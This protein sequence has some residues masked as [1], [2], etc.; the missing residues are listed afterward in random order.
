MPKP[1]TSPSGQQA[2]DSAKGKKTA[3]IN[4]VILKR[5]GDLKTLLSDLV[6]SNEDKAI[7]DLDLGQEIHKHTSEIE[8]LRNEMHQFQ[9]GMLSSFCDALDQRLKQSSVVSVDSETSHSLELSAPTAGPNVT[10]SNATEAHSDSEEV[11]TEGLQE[12]SWESIRS[13]FLVEHEITPESEAAS[14]T[15][16]S[17][18]D[19]AEPLTA[20][21]ALKSFEGSL[22]TVF[23]NVEDSEADLDFK[24]SDI[25]ADLDSLDETTLKS[26]V[27]RQE[28]LILGLIRRLRTKHGNR[29]TM[30]S[31]Q[32]ESVQQLADE[33]LAEE[34][35][36]TLAVLH[37]QQRQGELELSL[38]RAK[39]SRRRTEL[40]QLEARIEGRARTLGVTITD[41]GDLTEVAMAERG[42]G[43]KSRR[44]LGAMGFGNS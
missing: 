23:D 10:E 3:P 16:S 26:V 35:R 2:T 34:I 9:T 38:E 42:T 13:A 19:N 17:T 20:D 18:S 22:P 25:I 43:T 29:P 21:D 32:L 15:E 7:A 24:H 28:Q 41:D 37:N 40:E 44:W 8:A 36:K 30:T 14:T 31:E 12:N 6:D 4:H 1:K 5:I 39:L 27:T 11:P 33:P